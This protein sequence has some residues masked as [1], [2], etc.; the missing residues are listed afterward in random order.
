MGI[1][2]EAGPEDLGEVS[3][4]VEAEPENPDRLGIEH[5]PERRPTVVEQKQDDQDRR[6]THH[7]DIGAGGGTHDQEP[8]AQQQRQPQARE[9]GDHGGQRADPQGGDQA[10]QE[11]RAVPGD[12]VGVDADHA[13]A[14]AIVIC[15]SMRRPA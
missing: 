4:A 11:Q 9:Q 5:Q 7:L 2:L 10:G 13:C 8:G 14:P 3:R 12:H 15:R 1:E 6:A